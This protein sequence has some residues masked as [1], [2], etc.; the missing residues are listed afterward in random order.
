MRKELLTNIF[1]LNTMICFWL[2]SFYAKDLDAKHL[3]IAISLTLI[4]NI[5]YLIFSVLTSSRDKFIR[6]NLTAIWG[7]GLLAFFGLIAMIL[8]IEFINRASVYG[9]NTF[10]ALTLACSLQFLCSSLILGGYMLVEKS[11]TDR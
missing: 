2:L 8:E 3:Y 11:F 7:T 6:M 4:L 5:V 9:F 10:Y 1:L